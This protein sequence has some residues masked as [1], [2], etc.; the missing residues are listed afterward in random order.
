MCFNK[1]WRDNWLG[2]GHNTD[3]EILEA[4]RC[5]KQ[6]KP[7]HKIETITGGSSSHPGKCPACRNKQ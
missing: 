1:T 2:C 3:A 4:H 7:D 6:H 5:A